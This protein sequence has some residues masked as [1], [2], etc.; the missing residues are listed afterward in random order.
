[1]KKESLKSVMEN[2]KIKRG[3]AVTCLAI[4]TAVN[5]SSAVMALPTV[6]N[7]VEVNKTVQNEKTQKQSIKAQQGKDKVNDIEELRE[8]VLGEKELTK[9]D[10]KSEEFVNAKNLSQAV[11]KTRLPQQPQKGKVAKSA[12][13]AVSAQETYT[14]TQLKAMSY[15][16]MMNAI[17]STTWDKIPGLFTDSA[18]SKAFFNDTARFKYIMSDLATRSSQFTANDDKGIP[19]IIEVLRAGFYLGFNNPTGFPNLG[20]GSLE[21]S[22]FPA[23][24]NMLAN[25][26]F[27][28]GTQTQD[29]LIEAFGALI[30]NTT[31]T[32]AITNQIAT[33]VLKPFRENITSYM[34][35]RS[36]FNAV[37]KVL[38]SVG[39]VYTG[40]MYDH[41]GEAPSNYPSC[42][43]IDTYIDELMKL[44][45]VTGLS[46]DDQ[47]IAD[48]G[49]YYGLKLDEFYSNQTVMLRKITDLMNSSGKYSENFFKCAEEIKWTYN[50][51]DADGKTINY[52]QLQKE[53]N[54]YYLSKEYKFDN[55]AIVIHA[56]D[57][58]SPEKIERMYWATKEVE[59]QFFRVNGNDKALEPNNTD[60]VL[61][62]KIFNSP[63]EYKMNYY[64]N[65][66]G[67]DNGGMYVEPQ[68]TFY[69]YER[70]TAESVYSLEEL[71]RH[72]FTHYLQGKYQVPGL[73][74][75]GD[76]YNN[77]DIEWFD[78]GTAE[79]F[80]GSTRTKGVQPRKA[81][82]GYLSPSRSG[83]FTLDKLFKSGYASGWEFYNY[84]FAYISYLYNNDVDTMMNLNSSIMN[85]KINDFRNILTS[86][87]SNTKVEEAYQQ[88]MDNLLADNTV[89]TPLVGDAYTATHAK[90]NLSQ[91]KNDISSVT[92][93]NSFVESKTN[94]GKFE[95]FKL[96]GKYVG[97]ASQGKLADWK[98]MNVKTNE[99]LNNLSRKGWSGYDTVTC[100][101]TNYK[102]V[103][104]VFQY[105][106]VFRGL[107][108]DNSEIVTPE[109]KVP[110]AVIEA[111]STAKVN[112]TVNF[113]G[114]KSSD[115]DGNIASYEWNFGDNTTS[116]A[117]NPTHSYTKEGTYNV[118]L[119]VT[120]DKGAVAQTSFVVMVTKDEV[121]L[122]GGGITT[123]VESNNSFA[124]ADKQGFIG[125][126][127]AVN[128][129]ISNSSDKDVYAFEVDKAGKVNVKV[130]GGN[131]NLTWTVY[132]AT[133]LGSYVCWSQYSEGDSTRGSFDATT[134]KYY[135][136]VYPIS[137]SVANQ[138][139]SV[140][141]DGIKS[142]TGTGEVPPVMDQ[143]QE[144]EPNDTIASAN[145]SIYNNINA[146]GTLA[147]GGDTD[148]FKFDVATPGKVNINV[149]SDSQQYTWV[150][151]KENNQNSFVCWSQES[152]AEGSK[153]SF[154]AT[155]GKYCIMLYSLS[156]EKVNY[157]IKING[158]K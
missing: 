77:S 99:M 38:S 93:I 84:G 46:S 6:G 115:V 10:K 105:D 13:K 140:L 143:I 76:F 47:W 67:T 136:V 73:W 54:D 27:A 135:V 144:E 45:A 120:D 51:K 116:N 37:Y 124:E 11:G 44:G 33:K 104:G 100:Y 129:T 103:N 121:V 63:A 55:G 60:K 155:E 102:V 31:S 125:N 9:G 97:T 82:L 75:Q 148:I 118:T 92:G 91:I 128:A 109:N 39:Y 147:T 1:M 29:D 18:E 70:T 48:N 16:D 123:E 61:T 2:N 26:N 142:Y 90:R 78:E 106:I 131:S 36:K 23:M 64:I 20:N 134:G 117:M 80:A 40:E 83:R 146:V 42:G 85:Y 154:D 86:Q 17:A 69:T 12:M 32:P 14:L 79:F 49:I 94:S 130:T 141:V 137:S 19:T 96:E 4:F 56:G 74:G 53:G 30:G 7:K 119:K 152:N 95:T 81:I 156:N 108:N 89:G 52:E 151:F 112:E 71:F 153:G 110:T 5:T 58:V 158:I 8:L 149:N 127:T 41:K 3:L 50:S 24:N 62:I 15:T 126:N 25:P 68:G 28:F 122:P 34:K 43:K 66:I 65:G 138:Q 35:V 157:N 145:V 107:L 57:K 111:N 101:F 133:D 139:Y 132:K 87:A 113:K 88:H 150:V 22:C 21:S 72:E 114:E 98:A 59:S